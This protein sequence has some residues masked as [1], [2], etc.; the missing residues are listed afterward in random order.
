MCFCYFDPFGSH[1]SFAVLHVHEDG[2]GCFALQTTSR[3]R[4]CCLD[5]LS[6]GLVKRIG[7]NLKYEFAV[8]WDGL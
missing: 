4:G 6:G 8:E 1:R 7:V 3:V 2:F 5:S